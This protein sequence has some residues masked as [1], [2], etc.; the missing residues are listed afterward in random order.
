MAVRFPA[1]AVSLIALAAT[2]AFAEE[3]TPLP[4]DA[5]TFTGDPIATIAITSADGSMTQPG[6]GQPGEPSLEAMIGQMILIGFPGT[7]ATE[8]WPARAARLIHEGRIGGVVLY[9]FNVVDPPQVKA[10]NAALKDARLDLRPFICVDQEGGLIQRLPETKGFVGLPGAAEIS[11]MTPDQ[12]YLLDARAA[13]ELADLGFNVN[14]GPVV[15]LDIN[16]DNPA[17]GRLK[18]SFGADP[19]KVIE[20]AR[21]F[22]NAHEQSGILTVAKHFPGDGSARNDPHDDIVD[23]STTWHPSELAPYRTLITAGFVDMV[24]VGHVIEPEFSDGGNTPASLSVRAIEGQLRGRLR[25]GGLVVT[26][27]LDMGAIRNR[28]SV[29][30]AAVMAI[31]AGADLVIVANHKQ[32]DPKIADDIIAAISKAVADGKIRRDQIEQAYRLLVSQKLRIATQRSF[33]MR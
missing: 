12:A 7:K 17:I 30:D 18:R 15:D 14:F 10:L 29:E 27:D 33:V 11:R 28:Y 13:R 3:A 22:I 1:L 24:M 9:S 6:G 20:Y 26:D 32:P 5:Q 8:E 21:E 31:R 4:V 25:F 2:T 23:V 19:V 16:P